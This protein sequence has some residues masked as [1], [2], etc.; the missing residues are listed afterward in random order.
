LQHLTHGG[1][2]LVVRRVFEASAA[3]LPLLALLFTPIVVGMSSLYSWSDPST[4]AG[5]AILRGKAAYLNQTGFVLRAIL[6]FAIWITLALA[7]RRRSRRQDHSD[8]PRLY[9][10]LRVWC[11]AGLPLY[12]VC[13]TFA[14]IDW[15]MS[16]D[17]HWLSSIYGFQFVGGHAVAAIAFLHL[18]VRRLKQT[19]K[20]DRVIA[21]RHVE[22]YAKL[23][24]AFILLWGYFGVSQFL[25][26]WSANIPEEIPWYLRRLHGGWQGVSL[27]LA[28]LHFAVPFAALLSRGVRRS[29]RLLAMVGVLL[30]AMRWVD[31]FFQVMPTFDPRPR[32]HWLDVAAVVGVGGAFVAM[33]ARNLKNAPMLPVHDPYLPEALAKG[34][35]HG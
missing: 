13:A 14:S 7:I 9:H 23:T 11:G 24:L 21:T 28:L 19:E 20:Y 22:D 31:L 3:T 34:G 18:V 26:I 17:P 33:F 4:V 5:D 29:P 32:L 25:I 1:W 15:L 2:G 27:V 30:L 12:V 10:V 35:H 16:L 8:D 6:Y